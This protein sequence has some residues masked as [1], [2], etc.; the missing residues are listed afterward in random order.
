[1]AY[2]K[3]MLSRFYA[4]YTEKV[5]QVRTRLARPLTYAEKV[6]FAHLASPLPAT[7]RKSVV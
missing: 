5:A 4:A 7:D 2:D 1:M 3:D 6:L